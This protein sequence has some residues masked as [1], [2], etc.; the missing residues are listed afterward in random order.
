MCYR[1]LLH[2]CHM[3][4]NDQKIATTDH[5]DLGSLQQGY[6]ETHCPHCLKCSFHQSTSPDATFLEA[7]LYRR[8]TDF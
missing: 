3:Q 2:Q 1:M 4:Q 8:R 7:L 6:L 5:Y